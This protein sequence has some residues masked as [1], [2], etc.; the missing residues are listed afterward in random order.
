MREF[1]ETVPK[2]E[3]KEWDL[4]ELERANPIIQVAQELG[5]KVQGSMGKCFK[6]DR[7]VPDDGKSTLF[8]N[9]ARNTFHCRGCQDVGGTVIDLVCQYRGWDRQRAIEWLSHRAEFDRF[10]EGLYH[11]KGRKK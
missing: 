9:P 2:M 7:H 5:I 4:Q 10:T 6:K 3:T 1:G 11:G 8:F